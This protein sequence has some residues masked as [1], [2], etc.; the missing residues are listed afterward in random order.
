MEA[1]EKLLRIATVEEESEG[2]FSLE[3]APD[4]VTVPATTENGTDFALSSKKLKKSIASPQAG[5]KKSGFWFNSVCGIFH[6]VF[7]VAPET[8]YF[9]D[10]EGTEYFVSAEKFCARH[11]KI[12]VKN[13]LHF[14]IHI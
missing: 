2:F 9:A 13:K 11:I 5:T 8:E 12:T 3:I 4:G 6:A 10:T 14:F 1:S 7:S